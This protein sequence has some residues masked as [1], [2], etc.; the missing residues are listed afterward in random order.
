MIDELSL[1]LAPKTV[2]ALMAIVRTVNRDGTTV[3]IVEQ[4]VNRAL[5]PRRAG[6]VPRTGPG[7]LRRIHRELLTH[8][9]LL[10]PVF[11]AVPPRRWGLTC[12]GTVSVPRF[13]LI[14]GVITGP[15][16]RAARPRARPHLPHL[17]VLN[18]AQ[19]Q[20]GVVAAVLMVKPTT[21]SG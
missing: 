12:A 1:G 17:R 2:E 18:F 14:E 4:S 8:D 13:V 11:L 10:R 7:P 16:L 3:I 5:E 9:E 21:T 19:G 6:G 20:L 15:Q